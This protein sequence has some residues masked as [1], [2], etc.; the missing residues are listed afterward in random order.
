MITT[1]RG[2]PKLRYVI[3]VSA[4][5]VVLA[6]WL[7]DTTGL[8]LGDEG[9]LWYG[10]LRTAEGDVPIRDFRSYDPGRYYWCAA[11][12]HLFGDGLLGL[13]RSSAVFQLLGLLCGLLALTRV[14][15]NPFL[16]ASCG[17]CMTLWMQPVYKLFEP[18]V[19]MMAIWFGVRLLEK[20]SKA[21]LLVA[22]IFVG[23]AAFVG[24]NL[25]LYCFLAFA[26]IILYLRFK[27][28]TLPLWRS[29]WI[30]TVGIVVGYSP[31]LAMIVFIPGYASSFIDS[32][33]FLHAR[34]GANLGLPVP[35]PWSASLSSSGLSIVTELSLGVS[36]LLFPIF[37]GGS[38]AYLLLAPRH[39]I[40][41][42]HLLVACLFVGLF[43]S[44]HAF[45]RA[46]L[47]H[48]SGAIHPV[49]MGLI[50]A[51][52]I[53]GKQYRRAIL[54]AALIAATLPSATGGISVLQR[55]RLPEKKFV[56]ADIR[57]DSVWISRRKAHLLNSTQDLVKERVSAEES[58]LIAP[59][60]TVLYPMLGRKA[61]IWDPYLLWPHTEKKQVEMIADLE[62]NNTQWALV[63][64][65]AVDNTDDRSLRKAQPLL[66]AY[67][68]REFEPVPV[69]G[70]TPDTSL[71]RRKDSQGSETKPELPQ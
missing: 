16:L 4:V 64:F 65:G 49:L 26:C 58:I 34:G 7:Q 5:L 27:M 10:T 21:H 3:L 2:L 22:G 59:H 6:H 1:D 35:W 46:E 32:V 23:L 41:E 60:E 40:A 15:R 54:S 28:H 70:F 71:M 39:R 17:I 47:Y 66:W 53:P 25:G 42:R 9:Y 20:P 12:S 29:V 36:F 33:V 48:L 52:F 24:R 51:A 43:Y 30:W 56:L 62:K 55:L 61:P 45:S 57:G 67:L 50:A 63:F 44:H 18:A 31:Q 14:I 37:L 38:V 8:S 69:S 68:A 13:R 11:F 19:A